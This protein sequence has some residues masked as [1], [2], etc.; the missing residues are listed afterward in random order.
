MKAY[1]HSSSLSLQKGPYYSITYFIHPYL[2]NSGINHKIEPIITM[3]WLTPLF[4]Y[5]LNHEGEFK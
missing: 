1:Y 4:T 3:I 5:T 2:G